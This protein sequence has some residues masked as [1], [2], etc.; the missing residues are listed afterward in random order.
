MLH[1]FTA[2]TPL[3][4]LNTIVDLYSISVINLS[5]A[6]RVFYKGLRYQTVNYN[7]LVF[8][9]TSQMDY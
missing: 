5:K 1:V 3:K 9:V 2:S 4:V 8:I 6:M 7:D